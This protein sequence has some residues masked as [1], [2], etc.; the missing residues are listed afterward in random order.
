VLIIPIFRRLRQ[1]RSVN[2]DNIAGPYSKKR[3]QSKGREE[4]ENK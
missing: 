4:K 1:D 3:N 2:L